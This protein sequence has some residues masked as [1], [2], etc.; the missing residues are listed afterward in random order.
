MDEEEVC[1]K[2]QVLSVL[3]A[4]SAITVATR[5][6]DLA[7]KIFNEELKKWERDTLLGNLVARRE[8]YSRHFFREHSVLNVGRLT[9]LTLLLLG[10]P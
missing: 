2:C 9:E 7:T 8:L 3:D 10:R 5:L 1:P 4:D 6:V